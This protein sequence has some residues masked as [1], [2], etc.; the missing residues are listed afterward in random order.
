MLAPVPVAVKLIPAPE[1]DAET[2][3]ELELIV[4]ASADAKVLA[5]LPEP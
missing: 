3:V 2:I 5:V 1:A 4:L